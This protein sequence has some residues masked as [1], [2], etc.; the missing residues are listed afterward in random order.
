MG[1][2][3][4][5]QQDGNG[6]KVRVH[7]R[8]LGGL[9]HEGANDLRG[10]LLGSVSPG[11]REIQVEDYAR[12]EGTGEAQPVEAWLADRGRHSL[13]AVGYF[14]VASGDLQITKSDRD[15][16]GTYFPRALDVMLLFTLRG[17]AAEVADV[18]VKP[19]GRMAERKMPVP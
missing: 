3:E 2:Y 5:W 4:E 13:P 16:F 10:I 19:A 14:P 7:R 9:A 18:L 15:L 17:G 6:L 12:L 1:E 8:V 11:T